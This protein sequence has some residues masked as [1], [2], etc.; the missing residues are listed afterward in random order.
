MFWRRSVADQ[1]DEELDFHL[2][3]VTRELVERGQSEQEA[4]AEAVRR[5]GDLAAVGA[6][7]RR[8]GL[9]HEREERRAEYLG[10]LRQDVHLALR[11]LRRA[12]ASQIGG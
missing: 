6:S 12:P 5:F 4:R 2:E 3:M 1:V 11:H 8:Y 9:E 10:E 7:C